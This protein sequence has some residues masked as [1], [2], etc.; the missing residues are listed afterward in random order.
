MQ[1]FGGKKWLAYDTNSNNKY[2]L[3]GEN[4]DSNENVMTFL[5]E[6]NNTASHKAEDKNDVN[7]NCF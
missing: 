6:P 1:H 3:I 5:I 2:E 7:N 4:D